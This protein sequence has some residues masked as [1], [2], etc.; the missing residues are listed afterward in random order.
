MPCQSLIGMLSWTRNPLADAGSRWNRKQRW[1]GARLDSWHLSCLP[2]HIQAFLQHAFL[3]T[4]SSLVDVGCKWNR[5]Q[6]HCIGEVWSRAAT[7]NGFN[8]SG[9]GGEGTRTRLGIGRS[10]AATRSHASLG[11][12]TTPTPTRIELAC[13]AR[14]CGC[15]LPCQV[16][17]G[18]PSCC[19]SYCNID[20]S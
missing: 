2:F 13:L 16:C 18:D 11:R 7:R 12:P 6:R 14:A 4:R 17:F 19:W 3:V 20:D 9:R 10:G 5:R 8:R 15:H 1:F